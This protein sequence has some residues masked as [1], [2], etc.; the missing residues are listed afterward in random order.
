MSLD[1]LV[2]LIYKP[3]NGN[4]TNRATE[5][6]QQLWEKGSR[7][8]QGAATKFM[9]R[10]PGARDENNVVYAGLIHPNNPTSGPYAGMSFCL[11][12]GTERPCLLTFVI[13]TAGLDPDHHLLGRPGHRRKVGAIHQWLNHKHGTGVQIAWSKHEPTRVDLDLPA[14]FANSWKQYEKPFER[15]GKWMY[16]VYVPTD[17]REATREA[18]AAMLDV[19]LEERGETPLASNRQDSDAIRGQWQN[20]LMPHTSEEEVVQLLAR[21]RYVIVQGPPGTGKT[22][23]A[24]GILRSR[25][26]NHGRSVQFHPN[27]TYENFVGGLSPDTSSGELGL[28]FR[29]T[30]G[31]LMEAADAAR[32]E[33]AKPYLLHIDE[34]NRADLGKVLG[35]AIYLFEPSEQRTITLPPPMAGELSLPSNLHV[36]GTMNSSDRSIAVLDVAIRRRFAFVDLWPQQQVVQRESCSWMV[37]AFQRLVGVFTEHAS[38]KGLALLPGHSYFLESDEKNAKRK[39][40]VELR[41]L[42]V[43]YLSQGYVAGFAEE[44]RGYLQWLDAN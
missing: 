16:G 31:V 18:L 39:L 36:I 4:W 13:G 24:M 38:D 40:R 25:Y 8:R 17:D 27:T 44:I 6:F 42:L 21:R 3:D 29:R 7:Y 15:Y 20:F 43:E 22:H 26:A 23:T 19:L 11:M 1:K 14:Q 35:E 41:P 33:P 5:A 10:A 30:P 34:I 28:R 2:D 32:R 37:Q 9:I 12:P